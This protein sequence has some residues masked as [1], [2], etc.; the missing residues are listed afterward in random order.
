MKQ[1][2]GVNGKAA[3]PREGSSAKQ[4][5]RNQHIKVYNT[6]GYRPVRHGGACL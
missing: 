4:Q 3:A 6:H 2:Q 1:T 5:I